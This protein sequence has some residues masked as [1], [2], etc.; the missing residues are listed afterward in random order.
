MGQLLTPPP[1]PASPTPAPPT[2]YGDGPVDNYCDTLRNDGLNGSDFVPIDTS[3]GS[4]AYVGRSLS[5]IV[6]I[7]DEE[8][9]GL[10][11]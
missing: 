11:F 2:S 1:I 10:G 9:W 5:M 3:S 4:E 8:P 6:M 7:N